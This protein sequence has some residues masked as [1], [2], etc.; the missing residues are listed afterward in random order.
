VFLILN[1]IHPDSWSMPGEK[2]SMSRYHFMGY[3]PKR[4]VVYRARIP[5]LQAKQKIYHIHTNRYTHGEL[6]L[7]TEKR[8][9]QPY[10]SFYAEY[11][12]LLMTYTSGVIHSALIYRHMQ[13]SKN[14]VR[15]LSNTYIGAWLSE[16]LRRCSNKPVV[17]SIPVTTEFFLIPC[18]FNQVPKWFG[19]HYNL[20]VP[21]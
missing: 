13:W 9:S 12:I 3:L 4:P 14:K 11:Q 18:D 17:G 21:L 16:R 8:F 20:E 10:P 2:R 6:R 7:C 1:F 5:V 15:Q 19:T